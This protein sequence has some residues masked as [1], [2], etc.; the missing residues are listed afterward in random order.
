MFPG[1]VQI[2]DLGSSIL[3]LSIK[4]NFIYIYTRVL[5]FRCVDKHVHR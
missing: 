4:T 5:V 1:D 3:I 2:R